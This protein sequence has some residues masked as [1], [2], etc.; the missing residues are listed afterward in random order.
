[1]NVLK[2]DCF[3][4]T[5]S[6][7]TSAILRTFVRYRFTFIIISVFSLNICFSLPLHF[8]CLAVI[9]QMHNLAQALNLKS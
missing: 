4:L 7:S 5:I 6:R 1:M 9:V 3:V 2:V 8:L